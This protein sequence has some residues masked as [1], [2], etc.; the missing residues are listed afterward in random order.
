MPCEP[1]EKTFT[2]V[3]VDIGQHNALDIFALKGITISE[4]SKELLNDILAEVDRSSPIKR[5]NL[6]E[7]QVDD[8]SSKIY[9]RKYKEIYTNTVNQVLNRCFFSVFSENW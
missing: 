7:L 3:S 4:I 5:F 9:C 8:L 2:L 1:T 6:G